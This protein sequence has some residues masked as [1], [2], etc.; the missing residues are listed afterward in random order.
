MKDWSEDRCELPVEYTLVK[1]EVFKRKKYMRSECLVKNYIVAKV[2]LLN[3]FGEE[4]PDFI[5]TLLDEDK[6][7]V[8]E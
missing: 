6:H 2:K 8:Q 5:K 7:M 1:Q 4:T 3:L